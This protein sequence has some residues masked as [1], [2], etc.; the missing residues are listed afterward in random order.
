MMMGEVAVA[1]KVS[2]V[3]PSQAIN[4]ITAYQRPLASQDQNIQLHQ[5]H[6]HPAIKQA[7]HSIQMGD[8]QRL[9]D[10]ARLVA[11]AWAEDVYKFTIE[12]ARQ[13]QLRG[14]RFV[15]PNGLSYYNALERLRN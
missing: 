2:V 5:Y 10:P 13:H 11:I 7:V 12:S 15:F 3:K 1:G 6:Q 4:T 9:P 14:V 8:T